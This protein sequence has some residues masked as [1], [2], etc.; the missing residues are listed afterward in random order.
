MY[1]FCTY[2][3]KNFLY[4]GLALYFSLIEQ[5]IPFKLYLLSLDNKTTKLLNQLNL[6]NIYLIELSTLEVSFPELLKA[7]NNRS[8]VEYYWTLT[9]Y[10]PLYLIKKF[11][12]IDIITY[13]DADLVFFNSPKVLYDEM[14]DH[15]VFIIPH[16][17]KGEDKIHEKKWGKYNVGYMMFKND[18]DGEA[19]LV[20][21]SKKCLEWCYYK[22]EENRAGDQKYLDFFST[23][24]P[25]TIESKN[26][27]A[28]IGNW[29]IHYYNYKLKNQ[30]LFISPQNVPLIVLHFNKVEV[31][32]K[33]G[34]ILN[35]GR[36]FF[37]Y[38]SILKPYANYL[39]KAIN[40][41]DNIESDFSFGLDKVTFKV[42]L[43]SIIRGQITKGKP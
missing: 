34:W 26:H 14:N 3:D 41:V 37:K 21:W 19:L 39:L 29:N 42:L 36:G 28:G 4:R 40:K 27:G 20:W 13:L 9:P 17:L 15:S 24:Y 30:V 16:R 6:K 33:N 11:K 23:I 35:D 2:F 43:K 7:K 12:R 38:K 10:F 31:L 1:N 8:R 22:V 32:T 5:N 25:D 18:A